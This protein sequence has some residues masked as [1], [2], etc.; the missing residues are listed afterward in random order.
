MNISIKGVVLTAGLAIAAG[1]GTI[2]VTEA[3]TRLVVNCFWPPQHFVCQK[4]LP[5]WIAEVER[6]TDGR[7]TGIIPPKSVAAPPEQLAAVEKGIAD[8]SVQFNGL[9]Q[10]RVTG[11][12][13]AMNPF[14]STDDPVAMSTALWE[15]N[16]KFFPD[17]FDSVHLLSQWVISAGELYSQ[18]DT[19]VNSMDEL[20]SRKIWALPGTLAAIMKNI[21]AGVVATPAVKS[22][23]IISR[24]VVDAH[25]G[26]D[27]QGV[28]AFQLMPYTKS[29]TKFSENIYTTS[30]SLIINNDKW[31]EISEEDRAA[32]TEVSGEA[33]ARMAAGLW[34]ESTLS[35]LGTFEEK[36]LTIVPADPAFEKALKEA[37]EFATAAWIEKAKAA[38]IDGQGA[39]DFYTARV[40]E[41]SK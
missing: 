36:G 32:I 20:K 41:L 8:V 39:Y 30:F 28:R 34:R 1:L 31:A 22:N 26:L 10:N 35:A 23:E 37:S 14:I 21:G 17:E 25:I 29:M 4:A 18:T 7:V 16:Q 9:I 33:F 12:L 38:G 15:T 3:K 2:Q 19:P 11:P 40:Q 5:N 6:V 13:V 27:P 24:G